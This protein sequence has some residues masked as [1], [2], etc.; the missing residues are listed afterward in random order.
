MAQRERDSASLV[1][2]GSRD[3]GAAPEKATGGSASIFSS[4]V[5]LANTIMGTG[6]LALPAAVAECGIVLGVLFMM[7]SAGAGMLS[8]HFLSQS[9]HRAGRPANFYSVCVAAHPKLPVAVDLIVV[10]N[11]FLA[12]TTFLIVATDSLTKLLPTSAGG[13]PRQIWTLIAVACVLPL[14]LLRRLDALRFTSMLSLAVLVMISIL[15]IVYSLGLPGMVA[16]PSAIRP[17]GSLCRGPVETVGQA[18][19]TI[20]AFATFIIAFACQQNIFAVTNE[21]SVR[22]RPLSRLPPARP[23]HPLPPHPLPLHPLPRALSPAHPFCSPTRANPSRWLQEPTPRRSLIT[24][25]TALSTALLLY[26]VVSLAGYL[27]FGS[28]VTSDILEAYPQTAVVGV[29]RAGM[30]IVVITCYPLQAFAVRLSLQSLLSV[31]LKWKNG[32][33]SDGPQPA[34]AELSPPSGSTERLPQLQPPSQ[35]PS[36]PPSP[37]PGP[38]EANYGGHPPGSLCAK[39]HDNLVLDGRTLALVVS[40]VAATG[41]LA[42]GLTELGTVVDINGSIAG[43]AITF[44]APGL[45]YYLLHAETHGAAMGYLSFGMVVFGVILVPTSLTVAFVDVN[46]S[47]S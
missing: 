39:L 43:T 29:A 46:A 19:P 24:I 13:P 8:L 32:G 9:A 47:S 41:G 2:I 45:V 38:V 16:C 30:A 12:A 6:I 44:I 42:L 18:V 34:G 15:V 22:L 20:R 14:S 7:L 11:G 37:P 33:P 21:L 40:F 28:A 4:S 31:F 17:D 25:V 26:I 23:P 35:P 36:P 10:A 27:T 1:T 3:S 5:N